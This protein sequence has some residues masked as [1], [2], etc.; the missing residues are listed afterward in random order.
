M[1]WA[2]PAW[3]CVGAAL[4]LSVLGIMAIGTSVPELASKQMAFLCVAM[5]GAA[6][7]ATPHYR[8]LEQ[9][10]FIIMIAALGALVFV[11]IPWV[12]KSIV[13]PV[14]GARRWINMGVTDLQP[15]ELAKIAYIM[16]IA[17]YLRSREGYRTLKGLMLPLILSFIPMGLVLKEPNLGMALLFLPTLF[18]MLIAAGAKLR[19]VALVIVV[20]LSIAP[21][22]YP[23]LRPHQKDR[24]DAMVAQML[25]DERH[26]D[27]IG[28]QADRAKTLVG[29]GEL[30]G[31][32]GDMT[33]NL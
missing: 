26:L 25:G 16:A 12:P 9:F 1:I 31:T 17:S 14:N 2:N 29:A 23:I 28:F 6:V 32:G 24:I 13:K 15:S 3:L 22:S 4:F 20:G 19:H 33:A 18:A 11:L 10:S 21:L 7:I 5:V 30:L 8:W 27:D